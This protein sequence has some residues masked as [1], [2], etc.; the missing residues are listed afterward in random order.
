MAFAFIQ[1][2]AAVVNTFTAADLTTATATTTSGSTIVVAVTCDVATACTVIDSKGNTYRQIVAPFAN[3]S[4]ASSLFVSE[5]IVGGASHTITVQ[6][7]GSAFKALAAA[8]YSGG[9]TSASDDKTA[10]AT[11][12]SAALASG[13]TA[14]TAQADELQIGFGNLSGGT[15][16]AFTGTNGSTVRSSNGNTTTNATVFL[17]DKILSATAAVQSTASWSVSGGPWVCGVATFKAAGGAAAT[18]LPPPRSR[19]LG[20][21]IR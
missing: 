1:A 2:W 6:R 8:E 9:A 12:N 19:N 4:D 21:K 18:S 15:N 13:T 7:A 14:T 11:G 20:L 17:E 10:T 3:G 16:G 5:N